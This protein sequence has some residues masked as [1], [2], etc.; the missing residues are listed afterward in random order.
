MA[1]PITWRTLQ[2][3]SSVG[4]ASIID[5]ARGA[6]NDGFGALQGVLDKERATSE[7]NWDN[8]KQNN[9]NQFL[10]KLNAFKTPE[11]LAAAQA[12]GELD[13]LRSQY[14]AQVDSGAIRGADAAMLDTLRTR[15][16]Q[17][18]EYENTQ[19][20]QREA[21]IIDQIKS[22]YAQNKPEEAQ[23]LAQQNDF[24]DDAAVAEYGQSQVRGFTQDLY[25]A[26]S[27]S[28]A[29]SAEARQVTAANQNTTLFTQGQEAH[30]DT[31]TYNRITR[32]AMIEDEQVQS[33]AS[34][35][36]QEVF[37]QF[38]AV[39]Q[40]G[41][42]DVSQLSADKMQEA[43]SALANH[44]DIVRSQER[45]SKVIQEGLR[46]SVA[47]LKTLSPESVAT[48]GNIVYQAE[49]TRETLQGDDKAAFDTKLGEIEKVFS[50]RDSTYNMAFEEVARNNPYVKELTTESKVSP[51]VLLSWMGE[52][53]KDGNPLFDPAG[54]N[55]LQKRGMFDVVTDMIHTPMEFGNLKVKVPQSVVKQALIITSSNSG[56]ADLG[57]ELETNI[58]RIMERDGKVDSILQAQNAVDQHRTILAESA[59][60]KLKKVSELTHSSN[61]GAGNYKPGESEQ[62]LAR[63]LATLEKAE[64]A[65]RNAKTAEEKSK[66]EKRVEEQSEKV[67]EAQAVIDLSSGNPTPQNLS[68]ERAQRKRDIDALMKANGFP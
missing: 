47:S 51:E 6:F 63:Q 19:R 35:A 30:R 53:D 28:R 13:A 23:A 15:A 8:T 25:D 60:E 11:E 32:E 62:V 59:T 50:T 41:N 37:R 55:D 68:D 44:P 54:R 34:R 5:S 2:G 45:S 17:T 61:I 48:A 3:D 29:G 1:N 66:A 24:R 42:I 38:G 67:Q 26:N 36:E 39:D 58:R 52:K 49:A 10:D 56:Y 21:P 33:A 20:D 43:Q 7:A 16:N 64:Q 65:L 27:D 4:A 12:S 22:L 9:T 40:S 31:Q 18:V 46:A 57:T 14:G